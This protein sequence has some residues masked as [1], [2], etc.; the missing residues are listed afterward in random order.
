MSLGERQDRSSEEL[1]AALT[2]LGFQVLERKVVPDGVVPVAAAILQ[3][4][5]N[6]ADSS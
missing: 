4:S 2:Q 5:A 1:A 3:L 6:F